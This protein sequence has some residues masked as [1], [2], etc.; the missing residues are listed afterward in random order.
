MSPRSTFAVFSLAAALAESRLAHHRREIEERWSS[1]TLTEALRFGD[2]VRVG[3]GLYAHRD[4]ATSVPCKLSVAAQ[5]LPSTGAVAGRA[6]LWCAGWR[7]E[8]PP[9]IHA[10]VPR[11][12]RTPAPAVLTVR[13]TDVPMDVT[14]ID[15][16]RV[17]NRVDAL[18]LAWRWTTDRER[19]G[20]VFDA[21]RSGIA[22]PQDVLR[23]S[24]HHPRLPQRAA[25]EEACALATR[26]VTSMLE[27]RAMTEVFTGDE[28][29]EWEMQGKVR[30][31][32]RTFKVDLLLRQAKV[33]VEFDGARFHS[34]DAHR[35]HD[36][37]R[38]ALLAGEGYVTVRLTWEDV[39][40]RPE[41]C[42]Q[43]VRKAVAHRMAGFAPER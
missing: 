2:V 25:L 20:F 34:D 18:I 21:F 12:T 31:G 6:A 37:E 5:W 23:R 28:W 4:A 40:G 43:H 9:V 1:A 26:G 41:W 24:A 32:G 16:V 36:I 19:M 35:R 10:V 33:A 42:R 14:V 13:R 15:G 39:T 7:D 11:G 30:A 8:S 27:Y 38:D 3:P 29:L 22:F 17:V